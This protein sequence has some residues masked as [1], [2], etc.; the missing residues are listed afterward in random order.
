ME[1]KVS[2]IPIG[3]LMENLMEN[4][5]ENPMGNLMGLFRKG[6]VKYFS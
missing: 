2:Q 6:S 3:N 4:P 1:K 5:M